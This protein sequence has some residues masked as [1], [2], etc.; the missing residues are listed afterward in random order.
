MHKPLKLLVTS[1]PHKMPCLLRIH[2]CIR[3]LNPH[4]AKAAIMSNHVGVT[5]GLRPV[6]RVGILFNQ[7]DIA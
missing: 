5:H 1:F 6:H 3:K 2:L 7:R 4:P